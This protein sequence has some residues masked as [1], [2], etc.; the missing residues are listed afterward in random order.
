M[1]DTSPAGLS[2]TTRPLI[3]RA[4]PTME[5]FGAT[6]QGEG[7]LVGVPV[8]FVRFGGCEYRCSFC[9]TMFAVLPEEVRKN[10][11]MMTPSAIADALKELS[12][13]PGWIVVSGG[14]PAIHDLTTLI[15]LLH[16][17]GY[18]V[19][20][21]TQ[22]SVYK[23]WFE[24]LDLLTVSPKPPSSDMKTD[25]GKLDRVMKTEVPIDLK[26]VIFTP[27]DREYARAVHLRYPK[28]PLYLST[29]TF[30]GTSTRDDLLDRMRTTVEWALRDPDMGDVRHG[31]QL[32]VALW[33]H[34]RGV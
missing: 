23:K 5:V 4:L 6:V 1:T 24:Q 34:R 8:H 7:S 10:K 30:V 15:D 11:V 17:E 25:W 27:E 9:D 26:V 19:T 29:G 18:K 32:H 12:G 13:H 2:L 28:V 16:L 33:G 21:E 14:N 31:L 22:G 3:E 20:I